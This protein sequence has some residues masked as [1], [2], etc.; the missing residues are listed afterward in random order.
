ML[1]RGLERS[2]LGQPVEHLRKL[3]DPHLIGTREAICVAAARIADGDPLALRIGKIGPLP[4][5]N[6]GRQHCKKGG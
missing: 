6:K 3:I 5:A 1:V 2:P 4:H